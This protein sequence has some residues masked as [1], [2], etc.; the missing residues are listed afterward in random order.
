MRETSKILPKQSLDRKKKFFYNIVTK[1]VKSYL[2][3]IPL[4]YLYTEMIKSMPSLN[5]T[6]QQFDKLLILGPDDSKENYWKCECRCGTICSKSTS[7][8]LS[9]TNDLKACTRFCANTIPEGTVFGRLTVVRAIKKNNSFS[10]ICQCTCGNETVVE[11]PKLKNGKT[12]SCGCFRKDRMKDLGKAS[13][14]DISGQRF[15]KLVAIKPTEKRV[16]RFVVWECKCD[17]GNVHYATTSNLK[18]GDVTRCSECQIRSKGEEKISNLLNKAHLS[19]E[20]EKTFPSCINPLTKRLLRFDFFVNEA[21]LI[22]FDGKQHFDQNPYFKGTTPEDL[23]FRDSIKNDWSIENNIPLIR[24]PYTEL[25]Y[26]TIT[27]L[28]P[29]TTKFLYRK[30]ISNHDYH[31]EDY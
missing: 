13:A 24:I 3:N 4:P 18:N 1:L 20:K 2:F 25:P 9:N 6:G 30:E 14:I 29:L 22:E 12:Q 15:G 7:Y 28:N 26:L 27:D 19:Y 16:N 23:S 5:L 17:C 8:L 10:Y 31:Q 21:Y 11:G